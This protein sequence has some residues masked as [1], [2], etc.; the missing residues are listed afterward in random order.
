MKR[1]YKG[2]SWN[3]NFSLI[4]NGHIVLSDD[5]YYIN[6]LQSRVKSNRIG[7]IRI[8]SFIVYAYKKSH[9]LNE[10][11]EIFL[12]ISFSLISGFIEP[13]RESSSRR[14]TVVAH[15]ESEW[16]RKLKVCGAGDGGRR[17]YSADRIAVINERALRQPLEY[18]G[19]FIARWS[20]AEATELSPTDWSAPV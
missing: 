13:R 4:Q 8:P 12:S 2:Q 10:R 15:K 14:K 18:W 1:I 3:K 16:S 7:L 17:R 20:D 19:S 6:L 9:Q 5:P 11:V